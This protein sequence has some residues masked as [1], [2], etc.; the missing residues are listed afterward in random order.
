[1]NCERL[2]GGNAMEF[3]N[4]DG[5]EPFLQPE[6]PFMLIYLDKQNNMQIA[7]L[8][9]EEDMKETAKKIQY[10]G[11]VIQDAIEI[12]SCRDVILEDKP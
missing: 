2:M 9:T 7:W 10:Y 3:K 5:G 1:M 12:A 4:F 6:K 8:E 11:C